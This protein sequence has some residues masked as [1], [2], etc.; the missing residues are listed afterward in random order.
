L[1]HLVQAHQERWIQPMRRGGL[2]HLRG[3]VVDLRRHGR[4]ER[5][6]GSLFTD[7]FGDHVQ[8]AGVAEEV[9]DIEAGAGSG[10]D[11]GGQGGVGHEGQ[12]PAHNHPDGGGGFVRLG[13]ELGQ[14]ERPLVRAGRG[15]DPFRD[16]RVGAGHPGGDRPQVILGQGGG[17]EVAAQVV[18]GLGGPEGAVL[19]ALLR[20]RERERIGAADGRGWVLA[21]VDRGPA[22]SGRDP[23]D[24]LGIE[25]VHRT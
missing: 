7:G 20:D 3:D 15:Q 8:G 5:R 19:H 2:P 16:V 23:A 13:L 11:A 18:T 25:H 6:D 12:G 4:E 17:V 1:R 9:R 24:V 14:G 21:P 22:E 10:Q